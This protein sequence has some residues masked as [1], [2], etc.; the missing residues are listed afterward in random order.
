MNKKTKALMNSRTK[1][2]RNVI[3]LNVL[4][5]M[6]RGAP[7]G[8]LINILI[9]LFSDPINIQ[10]IIVNMGAMIGLLILNLFV[11]MKAYKKIYRT[12]FHISGDLRLQLGEHLRKL[13]LEFFKNRN[14]GDIT[15]PLLQDMKNF[16][17]I[18]NKLYPNIVAS[19]VMPVL[20][21]I[22]LV[23]ID[24]RLT[25]II[26]LF[27]ILSLPVLFLGQKI[28]GAF[29]DKVMSL[30]TQASSQMLEYFLGMK[31][32]KAYNIK[33]EK[34]YRL[35][36]TLN[37]LRRTSIAL[38]AYSAPVVFAY[39]LVLECGFIATLLIGTYYLFDNTLTA[40]M[41]M[42]FIVIGNRIY[43]LIQ[44][45][46][47]FIVE[48]R[49][50]NVAADRISDVLAAEKLSEPD[51]EKAPKNYDIEFK[52]VSFAY[53]ERQVLKNIN[54]TAK[55]RT[56]TA[57][58][59]PSG[60]GKTTISSLI[61]R[62]W[63]VQKGQIKVGG[64]NVKDINSERLLTFISA[65]FQDVIL[66]N[67]TVYNN[68]KIGNTKAT[69]EQIVSA[70]KDA[71][72][73]EFIQNL[74]E[75]Y[76]SWVGEGG[77]KLSGGEKQRISIARAILKDAP[78]VL[79]DEATASLDP[80]N[81]KHIQEAISKLIRNKTLIVIAHRLSTINHADHILVLK[82]GEIVENGKHQELIANKNTY[83]SLWDKQQKTYGWTFNN[84]NPQLIL[85]ERNLEVCH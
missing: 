69:H 66:F 68:I 12:S 73:H 70:A 46:G 67:D 63:D 71:N 85:S 81:E 84:E 39:M 13:S 83:Y 8:F 61:S 57:L 17:L 2:V 50:M 53:H 20:T 27:I 55:E 32:L 56:L 74:P 7:F 51:R 31:V 11:T 38:E 15:A 3:C 16:E 43:D 41:F 34:F 48:M 29:G 37:R 28:M 60:S 54:F 22:F 49:L 62:F 33:G 35:D 72:C 19:I 14:P 40:P 36:N 45:L 30:R 59:G 78:I 4:H 6:L 10:R 44:G 82:D 24:L 58:V 18:F 79:L 77:A 80:E 64:V 52:N 76:N 5:Y 26:A 42:L 9:V 75:G 25:A 47:G 23:F 65:I 21:M 1:M